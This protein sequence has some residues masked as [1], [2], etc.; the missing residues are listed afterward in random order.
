[1]TIEF[2]GVPGAGKTTTACLVANWLRIPMITLRRMQAGHRLERVRAVARHPRLAVRLARRVRRSDPS[3]QEASMRL[4]RQCW[5][6]RRVPGPV[7]LDTGPLFYAA[8]TIDAVEIDARS[9]APS[10]PNPDLLVVLEV[11]AGVA[12][13]RIR[14][15]GRGGRSIRGLSDDRAVT[16]LRELQELQFDLAQELPCPTGELR[17]DHQR[18]EELAERV[19]ATAR[20]SVPLRGSEGGEAHPSGK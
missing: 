9:V 10:L 16:R 12:V 1:M 2:L 13:S 4:L 15:R 8:D 20:V 6:M 3:A 5:L 7:V 17:S 11:D 14:A 18:P 19:V